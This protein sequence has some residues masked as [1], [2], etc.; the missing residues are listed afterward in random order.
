V[1]RRTFVRAS[2]LSLLAAPL[3][4][5]AQ[6][7]GK[8]YRIGFLFVG[9]APT[10]AR[11]V[12]GLED[13]RQRLRELGYVEGA[14][15]VF[16]Y[17][18]IA[19]NPERLRALAEE[20]VRLNLDVIVTRGSS[21]AAAAKR[22]TGTI[23][24]VMASSVDP[25]REGIVASLA[26][27]GGN[28]TGVMNMSD[29]DL[30]GKRLQ[31]LK[32]VLPGCARLAIVPV[33]R[34]FP[35]T[36]ED[37]LRDT[38]A[39][40]TSL[41]LIV[42]VLEVKD[43]SQWDEVFAAAVGKQAD[44]MYPMEAPPYVFHAKHIAEVALK[45]RIPTVFGLREHVD[46]GGLLSYGANVSAL[47]RRAAELVVKVLKGAKPRDLPIEQPTEFELVINLKTAKALGLTIPPSVLLRADHVIE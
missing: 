1:D 17:R 6:Q 24:I 23:P 4:A 47:Y 12:R 3:A 39:A 29:T 15:V 31:L 28:V 18:F 14:N 11:P 9:F 46:A 36:A 26:R 34:P 20:L 32:E 42:Q 10:P 38:G 44:V 2:V 35:R 43:P 5:E 7:A 25:V 19:G 27:P 13:L 40:A 21:A 41:G 37:W 45:H 33:P 30:I 16:E 22:A 8:V